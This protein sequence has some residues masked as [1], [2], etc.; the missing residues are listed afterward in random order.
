M[1]VRIVTESASD[2]PAGVA[3]ELG[4][5]IIPINLIFGK[6]TFRDGV[7]ISS[8]EFYR[9]LAESKVLPTTAVPSPRTYAD[10]LEKLAEETGE[11]LFITISTKFSAS[12]RVATQAREMVKKK[13]RV[14]IIDSMAGAI[15][16]GLVVIAAAKASR[17]GAGLDEVIELTKKNIR[18]VELRMAF[19]TLEY[20][21]RGG[22]IGRAQALLGSVLRVNP[23]LGIKDGEAYPYARERSRSRAIG[24]LFNFAMSFRNIEELAIEDATTPD[25]ADRLARRLGARFPEER[26]YRA[27]V[28]PVVGT[29]VGPHVLAVAVLGD[30]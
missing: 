3:R 14:E 21:K 30:R 1:V 18:R 10:T 19:D 17:S 9:K 4:I 24:Y 28:T 2:V 5:T 25:E 27:K 16:Q 29:H 12:H 22:R 7:D 23:I 13:V 15:S 26:I 11:I 8:E 20:L 6:E